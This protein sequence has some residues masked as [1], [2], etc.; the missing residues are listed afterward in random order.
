MLAVS[1][2]PLID[3]LLLL[4]SDSERYH[5]ASGDH[6]PAHASV[7]AVLGEFRL[8]VNSIRSRVVAASHNYVV[9]FVG[10]G[11]VGKSTLLNRL[12]GVDLAPRRNGP[13]TACPVEF[14]YDEQFTVAVEY[15]QSI[16]QPRHTCA[17]VDEVQRR[18]GALADSDGAQS[19]GSIK[20]LSVTAPLGVLRNNGLV[21]ADTPGFGAA[22]T[23]GA[24]GSHQEAL[25]RYLERDVAQ[26]LW[27]VL[28]EQGITKSETDFHSSFFKSRCQDIIVTGSEDYSDEDKS[29][30]RRR[31]ASLLDSI[32]PD[33]HFVSGR[34][35]LGVDDL[36]LRIASIDGRL[37]SAEE[38]LV[39][40]SMDL[41]A[42]VRKYRESNPY[43]RLCVW[44][45]ATWA[46][47]KQDFHDHTISTLLAFE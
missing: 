37:T 42:W 30:F 17:T 28:A 8:A 29:R 9:A 40:I 6:S 18:L 5:A 34:T 4:I 32:P 1:L 19:S 3:R 33:F 26:V 36:S 14:R 23:N 13:C 38:K 21:I 25:K 2:L 35:G 39:S 44:N 47:W 16:R 11:N 27:V 7:Q 12:L 31:F 24:E 45:P 10:A 20:R 41:R 15:V 22:Q 43:N 46:Q